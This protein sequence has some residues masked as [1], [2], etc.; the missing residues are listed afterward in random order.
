MELTGNTFFFQWEV[1]LIIWLQAHMGSFGT[2]LASF[3]SAFG[4][5]LACVAVIGF[6]Y[7]CYDKRFGRFVGMNALFAL[8]LNP[9]IKCA[10]L[11]RTRPRSS[12]S[13]RLRRTRI[14]STSPPRSIPSPAAIPQTR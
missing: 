8:V 3:I 12:V 7:W 10:V 11:R 14:S 1:D 6:L 5:E 9:M 4:E 13:S 2:S